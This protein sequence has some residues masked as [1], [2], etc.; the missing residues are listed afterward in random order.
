VAGSVPP[1]TGNPAVVGAKPYNILAA[2]LQGIPARA[3]VMAMPG[4]AGSL[5][6]NDVAHLA[7]Y[8]RTSWGNRA[9][10][11]ATPELVAT[12]R[13]SLSLPLYADNAA[14]AFDC[15]NVGQG[16]DPSLDPVLI[17]AMSAEMAQRPV[18]YAALVRSYVAQRPD[19]K[20]ADIVNNLV[21][22]YCPVVAQGAASDQAKSATLK[23][24]ALNLTAYLADQ[25]VGDVGP[26]VPIIWAVAVG[27]S[28]A[29]R[30]PFPQ[31]KLDCPAND[32]SR[33]PQALVTVAGQIADKPDLNFAARDAIAQA[34]AMFS[35]NPG[36][37]PANLANALILSFCRG[38]MALP[39]VGEPE[40][41]A[42]VMRYG[43][44]VIEALQAK[45]ETQARAPAAT[46]A[47]SETVGKGRGRP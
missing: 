47:Q 22:A 23:R 6:D 1:L 46:K 15:P 5:S 4:F 18:S 10:P 43:Q 11:N 41:L 21:A 20:M 45:A 38:V 29:E 16:A 24:F 40:K 36:A 3:S 27:Y 14:R 9:P 17:A 30:E 25:S 13:A 26:N 39:G 2:M 28:L 35:G 12:W 42:G 31:S 33:V 37:K 7:N 19:A 8:V 44:E 32:N 34:D